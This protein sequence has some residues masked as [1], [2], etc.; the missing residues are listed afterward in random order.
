M[1]FA[2]LNHVRRKSTCQAFVVLG[3]KVALTRHIT[4]NFRHIMAVI[5]H[6]HYYLYYLALLPIAY[7]PSFHE[8]NDIFKIRSV[9]LCAVEF[10]SFLNKVASPRNRHSRFFLTILLSY[11][12]YC[13]LYPGSYQ[14][15][16]FQYTSAVLYECS[17]LV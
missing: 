2:K 13:S 3:I 15:V 10:S 16:P 11:T 14:D 12:S 7:N 6:P 9:R 1:E 4:V 5:L 8:V 17:L